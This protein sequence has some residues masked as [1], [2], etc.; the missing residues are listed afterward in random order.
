MLSAVAAERSDVAATR[1]YVQEIFDLT[2]A[3]DPRRAHGYAR[4]G[5]AAINHDEWEDAIHLISEAIRLFGNAGQHRFAAQAE[6]NLAYAYAYTRQDELALEHYQHALDIFEL[7]PSV[8]D[9]AQTQMELGFAHWRQQNHQQAIAAYKLCEPVFVTIGDR[10][11]LGYLYNYYGLAY[12]GLH[13]FEA[14]SRCFAQSL[15]LVRELNMPALAANVL[16]SLGRMYE[17]QGLHDMAIAIWEQGLATLAALAEP[18]E[19]LRNLLLRRIRGS[20]MLAKGNPTRIP[21]EQ[22]CPKSAR[23]LCATVHAICMPGCG[24]CE[25]SGAG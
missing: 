25:S 18:P 6:R 1:T 7:Y 17:A 13:D 8:L 22:Q 23:R 9:V 16:E 2:D 14:A 3:D 12:T 21:L 5:I 15:E 11:A 10:L 4:L 19:F 24:R 20:R